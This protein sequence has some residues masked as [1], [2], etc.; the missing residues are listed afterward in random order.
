MI[1]A[2]KSSSLPSG[3]VVV[4]G[5]SAGDRAEKLTLFSNEVE[6]QPLQAF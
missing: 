1:V 2:E 3:G 4:R 6:N 5:Y